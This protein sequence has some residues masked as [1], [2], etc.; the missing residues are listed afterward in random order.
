MTTPVRDKP[1][2]PSEYVPM[3][4]N[5]KQC[6]FEG[7]NKSLKFVDLAIKC[8]CEQ[9]FCRK[10]RDVIAHKCGIKAPDRESIK[11]S[12][13]VFEKAIQDGSAF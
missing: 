8:R 1:Q 13:H 10:H 2:Q 9:S 5:K 3:Q 11:K 7:C 4:T 6:S 12:K